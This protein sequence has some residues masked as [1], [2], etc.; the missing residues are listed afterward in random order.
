MA[1]LAAEIV[2]EIIRGS[3]ARPKQTRIDLG[4]EIVARGSTAKRSRAPA[5]S[6]RARVIAK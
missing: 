4:F 5:R 2:L 3:G 6:I 1:R